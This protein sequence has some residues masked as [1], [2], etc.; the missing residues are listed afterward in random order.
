MPPWTGK[1]VVRRSTTSN[2]R[3]EGR[4]GGAAAVAVAPIRRIGSGCA[5]PRMSPSLGYGGK[6][7][8]GVVLLRVGE[9]ALDRALLDD[10]AAIHDDDAVG[11]LRDDGHVVRDEEHRH[12]VLALETVDQREDLGL[13]RDIERRGRLVGD[14]QTRGRQAI[15]IAITT[16]WRM[17]PESSCGKLA[18]AAL[19]LRDTHLAQQFD[20]ARVGRVSRK[21]AMRP[22]APSVS[23]RPLVKTGLSE[24]IGSWKIMPDLVAADLPH[25]GRAGGGQIDGLAIGT[26]ELQAAR[27]NLAAAELDQAHDGQRGHGFART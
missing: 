13:D 15:A 19:G 22:R 10:V 18:Q 23:C 5:L 8:A 26:G 17:P 9:D 1:R 21:A 12:A 4:G 20:R 2:G 16:R 25:G 24:V 7:R 11:H 27:A 14:Q 6:Q 3:A